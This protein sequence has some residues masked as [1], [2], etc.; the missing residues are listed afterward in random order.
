LGEQEALDALRQ[1]QNQPEFTQAATRSFWQVVVDT[2]LGWLYDWLLTITEPVGDAVDGN[3]SWLALAIVVFCVIMLIAIGWLL[4][5]AIGMN[6]VPETRR[7]ARARA[8]SREQSDRLWS[9]AQELAAQGDLAEAIRAL[10]LSALYALEEHALLRVYAGLTNRE[11]A[12]RLAD[13]H[14]DLTAAFGSLVKLYDRWRYGSDQPDAAVFG[15]LRQLAER[16][17]GLAR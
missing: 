15:E 14:P 5:R 4:Y 13:E 17:R 11:H 6:L 12:A 1:I 16:T 8:A 3:E 10:Y 7:A 2:I 9:R